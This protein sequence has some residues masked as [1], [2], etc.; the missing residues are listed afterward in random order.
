MSGI[1]LGEKPI[2]RVS[3]GSQE[4]KKISLGNSLLWAAEDPDMSQANKTAI[5]GFTTAFMTQFKIPGVSFMIS[6]PAGKYAKAF[7]TT[8]GR[9]LALGDHFRIGS[10]TKILVAEA[11]WEQIDKGTLHLTDTVE[12]YVPGLPS[13]NVITIRNLLQMTSGLYNEQSNT[14]FMLNFVLNQQTAWSAAQTLALA[15]ANPLSAPPGT[16]YAYTNS[17]YI[18]LGYV[19]EKVTNKPIRD[20]VLGVA[21]RFGMT[22]T[23]WPTGGTIAPNSFPE[24]A[25]HGYGPN[26]MASI[27]IIQWFV[28]AVT[29][30]TAI[31]PEIFACAGAL[32]ST[33]ADLQKL[34]E[35]IR[36]GTLLSTS[37]QAQLLTTSACIGV[38]Q[39]AHA[40]EAPARFGHGLGLINLGEWW[41]HPG[42]I[43]GYGTICFFHKPTGAVIVGLQNFSGLQIESHLMPQIAQ[44][45]YPG[46]MVEPSNYITL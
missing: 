20:I 41:G 26:P 3:W 5:D 1:T 43:N 13:G 29:D 28:P 19:L 8:A 16:K 42:G 33:L 45:L 25:V 35:H 2:K 31:N 36:D 4:I 9:P 17:Q 11:I 18:V 6:G 38:A 30:Q 22:Q 40:T 15:K 37:S 44:R 10:I 39:G 21:Q 32:V 23:Y 7:G 27:P 46:S 14:T 24:P 12:Q 34:G